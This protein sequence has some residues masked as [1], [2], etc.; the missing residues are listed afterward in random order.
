MLGTL[1]DWVKDIKEIL[2]CRTCNYKSPFAIGLIHHLKKA[3]N[4]KP[5]KNDLR[6][7]LRYN[8][9][10]RLVKMLVACVLIPPLFILKLICYFFVILDEII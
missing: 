4:I 10:A 9:I 8:F 5:T 6:F 7:L 1:F 3:H 2:F